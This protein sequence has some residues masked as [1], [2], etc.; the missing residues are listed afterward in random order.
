M[1]YVLDLDDTLYLERDYVSSGLKHVGYWAEINLGI[2]GFYEKAWAYFCKGIRGNLFNI[3]LSD[4]N[5]VDDNIVSTLVEVYRTHQP[6]IELLPDAIAFLETVGT[7]SVAV[8]TDG[9]SVCQWAKIKALGLEKMVD[10]IF[11]TDDIGKEF[12]KP[13]EKA[14]LEAQG[15][16]S[17]DQCV[18]IGDN[19]AKDF[20]APRKLGWCKSVRIRR[21]DS[22]HQGVDTPTECF[23]IT[24]L[25][26]LQAIS[27]QIR[28]HSVI[29][30][31][32]K[33]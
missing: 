4:N 1:L 5:I 27:K 23:E 16:F 25:S 17:N 20:V 9:Y 31:K 11:V 2:Y 26:E 8:I 19:P 7:S 3:V 18:Y 12:W 32:S 33:G 22:L 28:L 29:N 15:S 21:P 10:A 13:H 30:V 6:N 24:S 14:F